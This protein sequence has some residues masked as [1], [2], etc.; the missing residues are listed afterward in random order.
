MSDPR[1]SHLDILPCNDTAVNIWASLILRDDRNRVDT[2]LSST[3]HIA[4]LHNNH[5]WAGGINMYEII[6]VAVKIIIIAAFFLMAGFA[7]LRIWRAEIDLRQLINPGRVVDRSVGDAVDWIPTRDPDKL[8]QNGKV[9]GVVHGVVVDEAKRTISFEKVD[10][11]LN[12]DVSKEFEYQ[13][14]RVRHKEEDTVA[15]IGGLAM[16]QNRVFGN[17]VCEIVGT[18]GAF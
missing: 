13:K 1:G 7:S 15:E 17:M 16:E 9:V 3:Y 18:R 11:A 14:W 8:Y 10:R 5:C 2:R 6:Q 12:L 4:E